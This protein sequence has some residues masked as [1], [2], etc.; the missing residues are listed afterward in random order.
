MRLGH[1]DSIPTLSTFRV[2]SS[3]ACADAALQHTTGMW[4]TSNKATR[5]TGNLSRSLLLCPGVSLSS[6]LGNAWLA[7]RCASLA[8]WV[9][10]SWCV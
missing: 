8:V 7:K 10:S 5:Y 3:F 1:E 6:L 9:C 2:A 4:A